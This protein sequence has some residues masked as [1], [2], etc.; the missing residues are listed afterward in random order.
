MRLARRPQS[1]S[2]ARP[3]AESVMVRFLASEIRQL[4]LSGEAV[5]YWRGD[6]VREVVGEVDMTKKRASTRRENA[7]AIARWEGEGGA[8]KSQSEEERDLRHARV[9]ADRRRPRHASRRRPA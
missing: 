2:V 3:V 5:L 8:R 9:D 6:R 7:G 1:S 4:R